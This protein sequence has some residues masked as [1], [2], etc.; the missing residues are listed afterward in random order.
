MSC[1]QVRLLLVG[2]SYGC[3]LALSLDLA[4]DMLRRIVS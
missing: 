3:D 2:L 4:D 1:R